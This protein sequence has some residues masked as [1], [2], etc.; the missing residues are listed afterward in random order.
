MIFIIIVIKARTNWPR[1]KCK[2]HTAW[3]EEVWNMSSW[4]KKCLWVCDSSV[5]NIFWHSW[6][7]LYIYKLSSFPHIFDPWAWGRPVLWYHRI[8]LTPD[9]AQSLA[10]FSPFMKCRRAQNMP[11]ETRTTMAARSVHTRNINIIG[12]TNTPREIKFKWWIG[13]SI[14]V[15]F[16]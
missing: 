10:I 15:F 12:C 13:A 1:E 14:P 5:V 4:L 9:P 16:N 6:V 3:I 7:W 2:Y 11:K 8:Q